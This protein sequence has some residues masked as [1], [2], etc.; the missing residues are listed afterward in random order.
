MGPWPDPSV[1]LST[2][3]GLYA[4]RSR[5]HPCPPPCFHPHALSLE[6]PPC[7]HPPPRL[8]ATITRL[9]GSVYVS[10]APCTRSLDSRVHVACSRVPS[11]EPPALNP[12]RVAH[13][14]GTVNG[15]A[16]LC[17]LP[18]HPH[19]TPAPVSP[20]APLAPTI[21]APPLPP[22]L[23]GHPS[24]H[25]SPQHPHPSPAFISPGALPA[26]SE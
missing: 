13:G 21:H 11:P 12:A 10:A 2:T 25:S 14:R 1:S 15:Q 23:L 17:P 5:A 8:P 3:L 7:P 9:T 18:H 20:G 26:C 22:S 16:W 24:R 4:L 19:P 6:R